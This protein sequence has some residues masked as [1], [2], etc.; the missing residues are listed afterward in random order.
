MTLNRLDGPRAEP[1]SEIKRLVILLHGYGADGNDLIGLAP[2]LANVLPETA[3]VAP[4]APERCE[5]SPMGY[6]WFSLS[7]YDPNMLRRDPAQAAGIY[8]AMRAGAEK[9]V[10]VLEDFIGAELHRYGLTADRLA[11]V[12]FSQGTMMALHVG[13]RRADPVAGIVG[14]SGA[15]LG[16][17]DLQAEIKSRPPVVLIHGDRDDVVPIQAMY[18]ARDMLQSLGVPVTSHV[19]P[20]MMHGIA[21]DG[22]QVAAAFLQRHLIGGTQTENAPSTT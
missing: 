1:R 11:L 17:P 21:N 3:F 6:Q 7:S 18:H 13:L 12:G 20:G 15:L 4:N 22:L 16:G 19:S 9:A 10:P 2:H 5:M 14:F 8:A